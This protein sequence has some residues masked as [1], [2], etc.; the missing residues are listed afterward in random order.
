METRAERTEFENDN[1]TDTYVQRRYRYMELTECVQTTI[2]A[3]VPD[4]KKI[5]RNGRTISDESKTLFEKR[6]CEFSKS[7]PTAKE[8][9]N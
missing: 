7:K 9:E 2:E 3:V 4:K 5:S 6:K 8:W 1:N